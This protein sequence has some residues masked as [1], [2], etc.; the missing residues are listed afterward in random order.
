MHKDAIAQE[1]AWQTQGV[2]W[3]EA[4]IDADMH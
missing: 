3:T 1:E 4:N 2:K